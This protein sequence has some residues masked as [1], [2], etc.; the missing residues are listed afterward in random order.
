MSRQ[1]GGASQCRARL[2]S[3]SYGQGP[4]QARQ[5]LLQPAAPPSAQPAPGAGRCLRRALPS[6]PSLQEHSM[7]KYLLAWLLG[8]PGIVLVLVY[9]FF[10]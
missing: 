4:M 1:A 5:G 3:T 8:V 7:G 9:L 6:T 2:W 10:H